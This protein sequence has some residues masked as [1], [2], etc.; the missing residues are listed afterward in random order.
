LVECGLIDITKFG[1]ERYCEVK[2]E[3]LDEVTQWV[4]KFKHIWNQRLDA[5]ERFLESNNEKEIVEKPGR[6]K[7]K[8]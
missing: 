1:R 8:K 6:K 5:L 7:S 2:L 3:K 4:E